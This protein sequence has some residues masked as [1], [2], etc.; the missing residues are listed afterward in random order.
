[1]PVQILPYIP[2]FGERLV[3]ALAEAGSN[4]AEGIQKR[5]NMS[6]LNKALLGFSQQPAVTP[7]ENMDQQVAQSQSSGFDANRLFSLYN[8][9]EKALG[10]QAAN[11]L[12]KTYVEKGKLQEK[13]SQELR[14]EKRA[15]ESEIFAKNEP[16]LQEMTKELQDLE[17]E[18]L[19]LERLKQLYSDPSKFPNAGL[20]ALLS[21]NGE[22]RPLFASQLSP[23]AQEAQKLLVDSLQGAQSFFGGRVTNFDAQTYLKRNAT[24]LNTPEGRERILDD[25]LKLNKLSRDY[26]DGILEIIEEKGGSD[27]ISL[28]SAERLWRKRHAKDIESVKES[29]INPKKQSSSLKNFPPSQYK[30]KKVENEETGEIFISDGNEWKPFKG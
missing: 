1:M 21:S 11:A 19:R 15:R 8:T 16:K 10:P 9:A 30:G 20:T 14:K 13:E 29:F 22:I 17:K 4:I 3:P 26:T 5:N 7:L 28:T 27:K 2:S 12:L 18:D 24:L 6:A 23:E 25:L